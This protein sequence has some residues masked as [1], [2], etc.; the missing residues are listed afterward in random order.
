VKNFNRV[1]LVTLIVLGASGWAHSEERY[2]ADTVVAKRGDAVVTMLDVDAA[3][4]RA[5]KRMRANVMNNPKRIEELI[6]R[7]LTNRQIALEG[8]ASN[9]DQ[10][11]EFKQALKQQEETLLAEL[12]LIDMRNELDIGDV[13]DLARERYQVNPDAYTIAGMTAASH[14]LIDTKSRSDEEARA[15][16]DEIHAR[17]VAGESFENLVIKY[18]DDPSKELNA[19]LIPNADSDSMD[20]AFADAVKKLVNRGDIS[21][22]TKSSFGYHIIKLDQRTAPRKR[23][24]EEVK[25]QI[26]TSIENTMREERVKAHVDELKSLP[27]EAQPE[28][29]ASLRTRY[30][31]K[32]EEIEPD[33][34]EIP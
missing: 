12:R 10:G 19:G 23:T 32:D 34:Q 18:S 26:V 25:R 1:A 16:A 15:L 3:L 13:E 31:T 28:V 9:L 4:L 5:P 14:I 29:V 11:A 17:A 8:K 21:P 22:V 30:L 27:I 20:P 6:E 7:L 24:F 33:V 2:P